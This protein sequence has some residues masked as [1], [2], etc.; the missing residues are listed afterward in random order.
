M[1]MIG[2][3][4]GLKLVLLTFFAAPF[5]GAI[6]GIISKIKHGAETIPYGPFLSAAALVAVFFGNKILGLLFGG[7][8]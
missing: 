1:A 7:L 2:S 3:I 8:V 6:P 4:I 5:L